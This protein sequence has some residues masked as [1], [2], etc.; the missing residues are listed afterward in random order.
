MTHLTEP[1]GKL[2]K[3]LDTERA[4]LERAGLRRHLRT[5]RSAPTGTI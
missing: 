3:W 5:V 1:Q 2:E 4:T